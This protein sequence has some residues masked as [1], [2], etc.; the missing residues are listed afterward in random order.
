[1][2]NFL[3]VPCNKKGC[4]GTVNF[5]AWDFG[6]NK[7][8]ITRIG[9]RCS[10]CSTW[11]AFPLYFSLPAQLATLML[12][13]LIPMAVVGKIQSGF[14]MFLLVV[15]AVLTWNLVARLAIL[16]FVVCNARLDVR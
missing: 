3:L 13:V 11:H 8:Q 2:K 5:S 9:G 6:L 7:Y 16:I 10:T 1:M 15:L 14:D 12:S 4:P